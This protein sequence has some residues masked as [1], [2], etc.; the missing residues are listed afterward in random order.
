M[1]Q[2]INQESGTNNEE[3]I[4]APREEN[5]SKRVLLAVQCFLYKKQARSRQ[6]KKSWMYQ[7]ERLWGKNHYGVM[8]E[9]E[10]KLE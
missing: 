5:V 7:V 1:M 4:Q 6:K 2:H 3:W 9:T 8:M 10:N